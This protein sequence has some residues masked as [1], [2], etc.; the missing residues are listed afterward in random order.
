MSENKRLII[1]FIGNGKSVNRYHL[2]YLFVR[3]N[4]IYVKAI[5]CRNLDYK[6]PKWDSIRY[7]NN[8]EEI[9][10]DK[11]INVVVIC[12]PLH[13][14]YFFA[15]KVL[16][17]NKNCIVEKPFVERTFQARELLNLAE[18]R[19]LIIESYQNR[20]FDSDYLTAKK[21][22]EAKKLGRIYEI[23]INHDYYRPEFSYTQKTFSVESSLLYGFGS[24]MIDQVISY[25]GRPEYI[26]Y[27]IKQL[28]GNKRQNDYFDIDMHYCGMKIS[29]RSSYFRIR[30]RN[31]VTIYGEKGMFIKKSGDKQEA[32]LKHFYMPGQEGFGEDS[33]D[34]YGIL[35]YYDGLWHE[36]R[37]QTEKG[38]YGLFYDKLFDTIVNDK[39]LLVG[40]QEILLVTSI[41]ENGLRYIKT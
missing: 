33:W 10:G 22:I 29:V 3:K 6:W 27:D 30:P 31:K 41:L 25:F 28:L 32:H 17:A 9:L 21:V 18:K 12:T 7:T 23:E 8:L 35:V 37:V 36:E 34:D 13:T 26:R 11:D 2:P 5:Y 40:P 38:D 39:G 19:N 20:R 4:K 14:H 16:N 15:Q 24:H 1:A